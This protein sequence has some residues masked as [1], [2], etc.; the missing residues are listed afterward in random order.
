M[1]IFALDQDFEKAAKYHCDKHVVKMILETAQIVSTVFSTYGEHRICMLKPCFNRHPCTL[2]AHK[3]YE[4][5]S[6]LINLGICLVKEYEIRYNK[7]HTYTYLFLEF[8]F[9]KEI[10]IGKL[11]ERGLL[12]FAVAMPDYI[13]DKLPENYSSKDAVNAYREY[14]L[15][16][17]SHFAVW[18]STSTPLWFR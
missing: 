1:N 3:S 5:L 18:K 14:Y 7:N 16:E 13:K 9:L 15:K 8:Y 4:N 2:W 6:W 17:K 10:L 12:P 11:P